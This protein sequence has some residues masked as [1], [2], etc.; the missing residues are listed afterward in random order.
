MIEYRTKYALTATSTNISYMAT[1]L[2]ILQISK[3]KQWFHLA[4]SCFPSFSTRTGIF[5]FKQRK[6]A[7]FRDEFWHGK[8]LL[9]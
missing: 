8:V 3:S 9:R 7:F 5:C 4:A 6:Y 1:A 2:L